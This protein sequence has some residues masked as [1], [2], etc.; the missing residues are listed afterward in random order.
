MAV[1]YKGNAFGSASKNMKVADPVVIST[2]A[3][4]ANPDLQ[5]GRSAAAVASTSVCDATTN[6]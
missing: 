2:G 1:A 3:P 6:K 5:S 4:P